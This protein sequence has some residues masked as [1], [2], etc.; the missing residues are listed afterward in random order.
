MKLIAAKTLLLFTLLAV[1]PTV[2]AQVFTLKGILR[3]KDSVKNTLAGA[4]IKL[5]DRR[6]TTFRRNVVSGEK[7]IFQFSDLKPGSYTAAFSFIG[8]ETVFVNVTVGKDV[9]LGFIELPKEDT[10]T[11]D[12][13]VVVGRPPLTKMNGDTIEYN[14]AAIKVNPDATL[15]DM[16]AK[17]PGVTIENGQVKAQGEDVKKVT[18]D[19]RTFF[20]DDATIALKN[21]P[22]E[23]VEKIQVFD[24]LSDQGQLTGFDDGNGYRAINVVT[25][26]NM[27]NGQFGRMYAAYGTDNRYAAGGNVNIFNKEMRINVIGLANNVNQQNFGTEDLLGVMNSNSGGGGGRGGGGQRGGGGGGGNFFTGQ[28]SGISKTNSIGLNFSDLWNKRRI[29]FSGSYFYNNSSNFNTSNTNTRRP[30]G[31]DTIQNTISD[32]NSKTSNYNHRANFRLEYKIDSA[33]TLIIA[34]SISFQRNNSFSTSKNNVTVLDSFVSSSYAPRSS[35]NNGYNFRNDI[36]FR[37]AFRKKGRSLTLGV[38]MSMNDRNGENNNDNYIVKKRNGIIT[39]DTTMRFSDQESDGYNISMNVSYTEPVGKTGQLQVNYTPSFNKSNSDQRTYN[40]DRT[41]L[42]YTSF[43][44]SLSNIFENTTIAHRAG[45]SYRIG[46][47]EQQ[48]SLGLNFENTQFDSK[49]TFPKPTGVDKSFAQWLPNVQWRKQF[50][51]KLNLRLEYR[52]STSTP[53]INQ[54]QDVIN[55]NTNQLS[56]SSGNPNLVQSYSH[57]GSA[58]LQL[59]NPTTNKSFF[60]NVFAQ[61]TSNNVSNA[62]FVA[63]RDTFLTPTLL[64]YKGGIISKP[65]NLDGYWNMRSFISYGIPLKFMKSNLN[66]NAGWGYNNSPGMIRDTLTTTKTHNMNG[67]LVLASNIS[68][69][70]DFTLSY[71]ANY[72]ISRNDFNPASNADF[73]SHQA[74]FKFNLLTK[75]GWFILNDLSN[76][77]NG[78]VNQLYWLWNIGGGKKFLKNQRGELRLTIFDLLK[79]N[80][81]ITRTFGDNGLTIDQTNN[82]L[83]QYFMLTFTYS[84]KNFGKAPQRGRGGNF[85]RGNYQRPAGTQGGGTRGATGGQRGGNQ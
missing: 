31:K 6:D 45:V 28:Q 58:R 32:R 74:N 75:N 44:T 14:A 34:P 15:G 68:E 37:H 17:V 35:F 70:I 18:I 4:T 81:S 24:R 3:D 50:S 47:R 71:S 64:L 73:Y 56:A 20:G 51:K 41:A 12:G 10:S 85:N 27:R 48:L 79:Q 23:V 26:A 36:T 22:A 21:L 38:N 84:L 2:F 1:C 65:V 7:G 53:S 30:V 61:T 60:F 8:Y 46:N 29:E 43:D 33:N 59:T 52:T 55:S 5:S 66:F 42:K 19:G 67:G 76:L 80:Q 63:S 11:L 82:V 54:L 39:Q 13:V 25:K 69:Y 16:L 49:R 77:Y 78:G 72:N 57:Q 40:F 83:T 9:D 62:T